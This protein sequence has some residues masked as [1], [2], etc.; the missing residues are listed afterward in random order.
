MKKIFV[1]IVAMA[2]ICHASA[3]QHRS[4]DNMTITIYEADYQPREALELIVIRSD[5]AQLRKNVD[6][7]VIRKAKKKDQLAVHEALLQSIVQPYIDQGW[8]LVTTSVE[9]AV[10]QGSSYDHVYRYYLVKQR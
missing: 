7:S 4:T 3:Q 9:G 6:K 2:A 5:S 8:Q 1:L 10:T